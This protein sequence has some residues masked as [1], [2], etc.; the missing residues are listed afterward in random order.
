MC[1]PGFRIHTKTGLREQ[2]LIVR[3]ARLHD[4]RAGINSPNGLYE[5]MNVNI[6]VKNNRIMSVFKLLI[7]GIFW[8][9]TVSCAEKKASG[10]EIR[11]PEATASVTIN[12]N[13]VLSKVCDSFWGTN[14]LFW[15][16]DDA[17][18]SDGKILNELKGL[19]CSV[20]RFPGGTA[21]DNYHWK[22]NT[23]DN[24][25]IYPYEGGDGE[26]DFDE[27]MDFC[28]DLGAEPLLVVNT[29]SWYAKQDIQG[30]IQEAADWVRYC[31]E[32]GY[33]VK[34]W[35]IGNETYWQP[36]MTAAEYGEIVSLYSKAMKAVNP[37]I[38][39]GANGHWNIDMVGTKERIPENL[40]EKIRQM[41]LDISSK[42]DYEAYKSYADKNTESSITEGDRKWWRDVL[43]QC[44]EDIDMLSVH[45]YFFESDLSKMEQSLVDL[46]NYAKSK[47]GKELPLCMSEFN[48]NTNEVG[49]RVLG[50]VEGIGSMLVSGV[51][52]G[53]IWP[54]RNRTEADKNNS[55]LAYNT[56]EEQYAYH[57][58]QALRTS[59]SGNMVKCSFDGPNGM[60]IPVFA[61]VAGNDRSVILSG[62]SLQAKMTLKIELESNLN[63]K[64][65]SATA[66]SPLQSDLIRLSARKITPVV[67]SSNNDIYVTLEPG[68]FML[69]KIN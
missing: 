15:I 40:H 8:F 45:W 18:L 43:D 56:K 35:E 13:E 65:V 7:L 34:Y 42:S 63:G 64:K 27:F 31:K 23:L 22:S 28:N 48:C 38:L 26:S 46:K 37:D 51:D 58:V 9:L 68:T 2:R 59:V 11:L 61:S 12:E 17:S 54:L 47:T 10:P 24:E 16:E 14:F 21:A 41:Y 52:V 57:V 6:A 33:N 39:I 66:Y 20:L 30:G 67:D 55:L 1:G 69:I 36:I 5:G 62:K 4:D 32:K 19:N 44:A 25:F 53:C 29:Q 3:I 50:L 49:N 60:D